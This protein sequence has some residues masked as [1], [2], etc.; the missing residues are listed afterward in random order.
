M[1]LRS[2]DPEALLSLQRESLAEAF[3]VI[4]APDKIL[5]DEAFAYPLNKAMT[6]HADV[7]DLAAAYAIGILKCR[8]FS[9][10]N[11]HA[12]FLAMG[13]FLYLNHWPLSVSQEEAARVV[14]QGSAPELAEKERR[15][16]G[17]FKL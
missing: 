14:W 8:P 11:E 7:A 3:G 6:Q 1:N 10:G 9:V 16:G 2:I 4:D 17:C 15:G 12:A 13:L 5:L